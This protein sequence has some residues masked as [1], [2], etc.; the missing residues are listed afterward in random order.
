MLDKNTLVIGDN[1][2]GKTSWLRDKLADVDGV[3]WLALG[4][5]K[6]A[7]IAGASV[8]DYKSWLNAYKLPDITKSKVLVL[9][10][11]S[12]LQGLLLAGLLTE[13]KNPEQ[14]DYGAA[15]YRLYQGFLPIG[16]LEKPMHAS[17]LTRTREEG[18]KDNK[19]K[20]TEIFLSPMV[21]GF[22]MTS[23]PS[24]VYLTMKVLA[25]EAK[26]AVQ[27]NTALAKQLIAAKV[28]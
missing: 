13:G 17:V 25:G 19:V 24:A 23:F 18:A 1:E 28:K 15:A 20:V 3:Y 16:A 6:P 22:I 8:W 9:D 21:Q 26:Y 4:S 5:P 10:G 12:N 2:T 11:L 14:R 7:D 27:E